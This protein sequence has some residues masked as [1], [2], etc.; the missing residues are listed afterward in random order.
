MVRG[1]G[2][3]LVQGRAWNVS[4]IDFFYGI[5]NVVKKGDFDAH[6]V[7]AR[8]GLQRENGTVGISMA[9]GGVRRGDGR[10][11]GVVVIIGAEVGLV[12][13]HVEAR[14]P[15]DRLPHLLE[16]VVLHGPADGPVATH[17]QETTP[18]KYIPPKEYF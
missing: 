1:V 9:R 18:S 6:R 12:E 8:K 17:W 14:V 16:A 10:R 3:F 15:G 2:F 13:V 4:R 11:R 5:L 7:C